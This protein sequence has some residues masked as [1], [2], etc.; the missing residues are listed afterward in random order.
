MWAAGSLLRPP[1]CNVLNN[2]L[3]AAKKPLFSINNAFSEKNRSGKST[4]LPDPSVSRFGRMPP[5]ASLVGICPEQIKYP[6]SYFFQKRGILEKLFFNY[7]DRIADR[8]CKYDLQNIRYQT[9][10]RYRRSSYRDFPALLVAAP[11]NIHIVRDR[12]HPRH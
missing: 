4:T 8:R 12:Q 5:R 2:S 6:F 7:S 9:H 10:L 11:Q 1:C 3:D